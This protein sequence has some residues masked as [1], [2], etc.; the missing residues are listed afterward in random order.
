MERW[1]ALCTFAWNALLF[2]K[3][4]LPP[5]IVPKHHF[6]HE[7]ILASPL[8]SPCC[9]GT[10]VAPYSLIMEQRRGS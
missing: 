4:S 8:P 5:D 2:L 3:G 6:F 1:L 9:T 7:A 10:I